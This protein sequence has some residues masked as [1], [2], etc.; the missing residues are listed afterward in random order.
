VGVNRIHHLEDKRDG[1]VSIPSLPSKLLNENF[2]A[3]YE[4][5]R[6]YPPQ[7]NQPGMSVAPCDPDDRLV[8]QNAL[9]STS[10][11]APH[12]VARHEAPSV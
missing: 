8:S 12:S 10:V 2:Q 4:G 11:M 6:V 9:T 3:G 5:P 1:A 7:V